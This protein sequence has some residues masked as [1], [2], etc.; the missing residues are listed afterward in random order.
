MA[1]PHLAPTAHRNGDGKRHEMDLL[2]ETAQRAS[3]YL[4]GLERAAV[5]P[6]P[7]ALAG[8]AAFDE[9]LPEAPQTQPRRSRCSTR[10]GSPATMAHRPAALSSASS[11]AARC[12]RRW[13]PTGWPAPGTRTPA[14]TAALADRGDARS[15]R[16]ALAARCAGA[17]ARAPA[18]ASSPARPWRTSR[19][20]PRRGTRCC[21][22]AGW[23]VEARGAVRRAADHGR[24]RRRGAR[25]PAQGAGPARPR[26]RARGARA[27]GRPGPHAR[28]ARCRPSP[29]RPSSASRPATST[30]AP[31]TRPTRSARARTRPAPGCTW[32]ARSACGR[33]AAPARAPPDGRRRRRRLLGHRRAQVAERALRQRPRLRAA[34][35]EPLRAAMSISRP[36]TCSQ[37]E[38]REPIDYTPEMSR[39]A[40]G[41]E[42]WAAL[43]SLGRSGLADLIER[44][45]RHAARFADG[46]ARPRATRC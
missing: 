5:F 27:G 4:D 16:A 6:G 32:T 29:A 12:R 2:A 23:D 36:P 20:W 46:P 34:T 38:Q 1:D 15:G 10:L 33:A 39:R 40:R 45:C 24:R 26:A 42:V 30:P 35:A 3:R 21:E 28:R 37:G 9:P 19:R 14:C 11:S 25:Q 17:A 18:A 7:E 31:S 8:L 41:V 43:R 13:P 44:N 22:R